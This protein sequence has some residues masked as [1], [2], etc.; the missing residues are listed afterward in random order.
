MSISSPGTILAR[1][2]RAKDRYRRWR[3]R[4]FTEWLGYDFQLQVDHLRTPTCSG[5]MRFTIT[6]YNP[7]NHTIRLDGDKVV[8]N[9]DQFWALCRAGKV[10]RA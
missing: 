1:R 6:S 3:D 10:R 2:M 8:W 7:E 5:W 9:T 4:K